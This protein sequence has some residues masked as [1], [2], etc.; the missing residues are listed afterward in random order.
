MVSYRSYFIVFVL[1]ASGLTAGCADHRI[2][3]SDEEAMMVYREC[4]SGS[5]PQLN[6]S[7]MSSTISNSS[8][9]DKSTSIA[10]K[11]QTQ[12]EQSQQIQCMQLAGWER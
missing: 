8:T 4:M 5:P 10:A 9:V 6:S 2:D 7:D 12:Q 11:A 3:R 1:L